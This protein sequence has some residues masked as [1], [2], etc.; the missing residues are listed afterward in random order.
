MYQSVYYDRGEKQYYLR[1]DKMG[2]KSFKYH[3]TYYFSDPD[4][5]YETLEGTRVSPTKK[6]DWSDNGYYE[7]DVSKETRL[8]VDMYYETDDT[9]SFHNIV[10]LD[11]ECVI[12]GAL[13]PEN[14][15][16]PKGEITA[17]ALYDNN[18][19][20]YFCFI[21][22]KEGKMNEV[23]SDKKQIIPLLSESELLHSFL[24]KWIELDPTIIT[25]WN[26]GFFD[27]PYLY[28]RICKVLGEDIA[29]YLSP[30]G[31]I[32]FTPQF[33]EQPVN[34][35]GINHLDYMLLFKKY[36]T[37]Q[38][39]SYKLGEIGK[40]YAKL[41]KI[42]YQGSLD[43]LFNEDIDKF[44]EYNI[45]DVEIIVELEK[46]LKFVE[47]TVTICHLCHTEYE[48]IYYSTML[49]EGAI[50]TYL[51]RKGIV[52]PNKPT[53]YNP[54]LKDI[55]VRNAKSE[56]E[57]KNI[58]KEEYD[59]IVALAEYAGGYLKDPIPGL[60]EWVID[61]DFTS[62]YPSII[63]S[64]NMGI[65]TLVGRVVHSGKFDNQWS[66]KELKQMDPERVV[67]IEKIRKDRTI[68]SS[69]IKVG[70]LVNI[71]EKNNLIISAPGV[72]FR[73]DKS[74]VVCE[75]LADWFAKRQEYKKLMKKA[76]KE[77]NDPVMGSFYDRRQHAYKIKLND[78]YGVFAI[79]GWR[80]TDGNK[81]ISKAITL[82][83]QRLTQESI[84]F[85]NKWMNE[86][87]ETEDKDYVV[88][89][90]TDSLFIQVKDLI[91]H[92][93]PDLDITNRENIVQEVLKVATEI[94]KL[95]NQN[96][97]SLVQELFNIDYPN[98][99]HY[100][101][102]KQ[103][104]VLER[105]YFAGKRRYAQFIVNK[106]GVPVEELDLKG[107]DLMK[108]NFPP[109]F[110]KF[111]EELI[112][113]IMFGKSKPSIDSQVLDFRESLQTIEWTKIL[114]PTGLKQLR[115]YI[116]RGPK[117]GEIF[118]KLK[119]KCPINTKAAI[120]YNDFLRFKKLDK[121]NSLFQV[122]DKMFIAYL[123]NNPYKIDVIGFNG[124]DDPP[125]VID[126]INAYID[127]DGIFD[128]VMKNKLETLYK[129]IGWGQPIFNRNVHKFFKFG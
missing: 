76:Y 98:E 123:K 87:L 121:T 36:I 129:D 25:G 22:D 31:K 38:E 83:G 28:Y 112:K 72:M 114:K 108:S 80:Y 116:E 105:G 101:D 124:Y 94:Q 65:E 111:G 99:A 81:F 24:D 30:L 88:T 57:K 41:E 71:I 82:T 9:P 110:K 96:L 32:T 52:S 66:L 126:F 14:I 18:S 95:A 106:E 47:L 104:V 125:E 122:G 63:R 85:V 127:R 117:A 33:P 120:F 73:K 60:Y 51:K 61:L 102:L 92:R 23:D 55:S 19:Q 118:S 48:Q 58:T 74:S 78:V 97:H 68:S 77:D 27:I 13:T 20:K 84:E 10:Y 79:N 11:I 107:L 128:G 15:K 39:P 34:L 4:G 54:A 17:I 113:Q 7:K 12:A 49:N 59:D 46:Q 62:L 26:S 21:L 115:E 6:L 53:T 64:L 2:W 109:L 56:Y 86:Q 43:K 93:N 29:N 75:I 37:K 103:E 44:I 8:L 67:D 45:R 90:D 35:A 1:D 91:K 119:L 40:K 89:S 50:L 100:F 5:E 42:E 16:N 69:Q 70:D 3:P